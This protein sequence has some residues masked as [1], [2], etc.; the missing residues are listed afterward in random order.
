MIRRNLLAAF[1]ILGAPI[2]GIA[3][4]TAP[5]C[6]QHPPIKRELVDK[7]KGDNR[8]LRQI[9]EEAVQAARAT[10][11]LEVEVTPGAGGGDCPENNTRRGRAA[12]AVG[13]LLYGGQIHCSAVLVDPSTVLTAA[14]CVRGF[15]RAK[16][17][18]VVGESSATIQGEEFSGPLQRASIERGDP[19]LDYDPERFGVHDLAYLH[20]KRFITAVRPAE[21][22]QTPLKSLAKQTLLYVG[23][24]IAGAVPGRK[25][26]VDIPVHSTCDNAFSSQTPGLNTCRGDSGGGIFYDNGSEVSLI[27]ITTWGDSLCQKFVVGLDVGAYPDWIKSR[28]WEAELES[29]LPA[30]WERV[31]R[32]YADPGSAE[33]IQEQ[34]KAISI[35]ERDGV[36]ID[37]FKDRWVDW[38][39]RMVGLPKLTRLGY[40]K[41]CD[42]FLDRQGMNFQ[43]LGLERGC[44]LREGMQVEFEGRLLKYSDNYFE[45]LW[46]ELKRDITG[47]RIAG[48]FRLVP[49]RAVTER[50]TRDFRLESHHGHWSGEEND[51]RQV[52][53]EAPWKLDRS[54]PIE[55]SIAYQNHGAVG[56][57]LVKSD[58]EFCLPLSARGFG[59][60]RELGI[61]VDA[62]NK[63]VI[64]G[65]MSFT[66]VREEKELEA[67]GARSGTLAA[68][69]PLQIPLPD[70]ER[71][72]ELW[73]KLRDGR[74][75][76]TR[77]SYE[78]NGVKVEWSRQ[79][80]EIQIAL[81]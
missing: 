17:E 75:I 19:H 62:G 9:H 13:A 44:D 49:I 34:L 2:A 37:H 32:K 6:D 20:L 77:K 31:A 69:S 7:A 26:C 61:Q 12:E 30:P 50:R 80:G 46:P 56:T 18:F 11:A 64:S 81:D 51:C 10:G 55:I 14:H 78:E 8:G 54:Q 76:V 39:G 24:G 3:Q 68:G 40:P 21:Y 65:A 79:M 70:P 59:G 23:F 47:T 67:G 28:I 29:L 53:I 15:D 74:E 52:V 45:L 35:W 33:K 58:N 16:M 38:K 71:E 60:F 72:Y 57:P 48:E 36:F 4:E 66:V 25:R 43:L 22:L 5:L 63:G 41:S 27:G 73:L 42:V 1:L